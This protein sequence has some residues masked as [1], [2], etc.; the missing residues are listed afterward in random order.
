M[1]V[2]RLMTIVEELTKAALFPLQQLKVNEYNVCNIPLPDGNSVQLEL[3][4]REESL[5]IAT[6]LGTVTPGTYRTNLFREALKYNGL[7][8]PRNGILAFSTKT[9]HLLLYDKK[10]LREITGASLAENLPPFLEKASIWREAIG[11][12]IVPTV[13]QSPSFGSVGKLFGLK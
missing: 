3:D 11:T 1:S 9:D 5:V 10:H 7:P 2:E 13:A 4:P 8:P 6:V 12:G